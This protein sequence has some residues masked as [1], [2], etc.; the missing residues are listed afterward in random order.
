M[1]DAYILGVTLLL[2]LATVIARSTLFLLGHA[3]RLPPNVV[4]AL[5][6]A[7]AAALAA[8]IA[9]DLVLQGDTLNLSL[10]NPRLLAACGA[11]LFF[12]LSR[13]LLGTIVVGM[14][15]F[16]VLRAVL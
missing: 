10:A 16:S 15:L 3:V 14:A 8:I 12:L 4:H 11:A 5:R 9:P 7:P 1:S 2:A 13:H 6:Y